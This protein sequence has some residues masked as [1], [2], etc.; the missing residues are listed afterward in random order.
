MDLMA[1]PGVLAVL[2]FCYI[3][4]FGVILA[5]KQYN[6][7]VGILASKWVGFDNFKFFFASSD[8]TMLLRNTL[9]YSLWFLVV[10]NFFAIL[11]AI[12]CYNIRSKALLKYCQTTAILPTFMSIVLVSYI[13]YAFLS[14]T[15]GIFNNLITLFGGEAISW[16]TKPEYWPVILTVVRVWNGI[17]YGSLLYYATMVGIDECLFEAAEID[18][19]NKFKQIL[20][21]IIPEITGLLCLR[22]I[23]GIGHA[24]GGDFGLFYQ[25]PRNIGLLYPTTDI[26]NTYTFR[27]LQEGASM[28]R[29]TAVGLFQSLSGIV[30]LLITNT[31]IKKIDEE[32][33]MF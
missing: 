5:F 19:A 10:D 1:L 23:T 17:G 18:G 16:Y 27:A 20:Y 29:T 15:S 6:P 9:A 2:I 21:V 22:L 24:M 4:M 13:V 33:S 32:K 25:I 28:G 12:L 31:I 11:F 7:N 30:L 14:P 26:F 8:F 3:P